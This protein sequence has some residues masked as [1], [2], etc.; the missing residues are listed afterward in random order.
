MAGAIYTLQIESFQEK[1]NTNL[2]ENIFGYIIDLIKDLLEHMNSLGHRMH[3]A[4]D[5]GNLNN[6]CDHI[7]TR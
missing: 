6:S 1:N 7:I 3:N 5:V 2:H 4:K